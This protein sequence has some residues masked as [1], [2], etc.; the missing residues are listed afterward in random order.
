LGEILPNFDLKKKID[1]DLY[2][3]FLMKKIDPKLSDFKEKKS[4]SP[5]I[6]DKFE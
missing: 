4:K 1:F 5:G 3:G 6:Y 2:K